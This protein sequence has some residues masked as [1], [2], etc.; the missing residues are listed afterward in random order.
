LGNARRIKREGE[1]YLEAKSKI[2]MIKACNLQ[3]TGILGENKSRFLFGVPENSPSRRN[4]VQVLELMPAFA[5]CRG[6]V[7]ARLRIGTNE[8]GAWLAF[9]YPMLLRSQDRGALSLGL[10]LRRDLLDHGT[11]LLED[12]PR[13]GRRGGR[14]GKRAAA[15]GLG[16][17]RQIGG[18]GRR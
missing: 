8:I 7:K 11:G 9:T 15:A 4:G 13:G 1:Q 17:S 6:K 16:A 10:Q 12:F 5:R 3:K 18:E 14:A 2:P